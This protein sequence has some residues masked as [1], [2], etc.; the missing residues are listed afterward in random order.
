M[1][2]VM[3]ESEREE[4]GEISPENKYR[5]LPCEDNDRKLDL[6]ESDLPPVFLQTLSHLLASHILTATFSVKPD[7]VHCFRLTA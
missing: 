5:H 2:P 6:F 1:L 7:V 3:S 4:E